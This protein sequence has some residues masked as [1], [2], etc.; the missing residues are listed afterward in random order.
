MGIIPITM[1]KKTA[2]CLVAPAVSLHGFMC[3]ISTG[4]IRQGICISATL[5]DEDKHCVSD[6]VKHICFPFLVYVLQIYCATDPTI[7]DFCLNVN[8]H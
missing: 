6:F 3:E 7:L 8:K 2:V 1:H 4:A 5:R